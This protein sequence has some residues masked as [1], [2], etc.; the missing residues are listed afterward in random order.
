[1]R[2]DLLFE[3]RDLDGKFRR[4]ESH[5]PLLL[6]AGG[7]PGE[8]KARNQP[9]AKNPT[10]HNS[11]PR[12]N[13]TVHRRGSGRVAL[14]DSS[15]DGLAP[16]QRLPLLT[17]GPIPLVELKLLVGSKGQNLPRRS[18]QQP[19]LTV[20]VIRPGHKASSEIELEHR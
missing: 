11:P 16:W 8:Q 4:P 2:G 6:G 13:D 7:G 17:L 12:W 9:D 20:A 18:V 15:L 3:R 5:I 1:Q 10:Y 14:Q 19:L